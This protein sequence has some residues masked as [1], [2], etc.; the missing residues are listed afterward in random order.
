MNISYKKFIT[1]R[2]VPKQGIY[3]NN[4]SISSFI[5]SATFN[6]SKSN[7]VILPVIYGDASSQ[8]CKK[9]ENT[10]FYLLMI[11]W[12]R[13][14][15]T[16][17]NL[18]LWSALHIRSVLGVVYKWGSITGMNLKCWFFQWNS[19]ILLLPVW[20]CVMMKLVTEEFRPW[21]CVRTSPAR[22]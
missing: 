20:K 3:G 6:G 4:F 14:Q 22:K 16:N 5:L 10:L 2:S 13:I 8:K 21:F 17:Q 19:H 15:I 18:P 11:E 1:T 7:V 12:R 9:L